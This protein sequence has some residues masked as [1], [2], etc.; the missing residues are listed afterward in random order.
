MLPE[1]VL[2]QEYLEDGQNKN[3]EAKKMVEKYDPKTVDGKF[4]KGMR[5]KFETNKGK[6]E[7]KVEAASMANIL[8]DIGQVPDKLHMMGS[9]DKPS[10]KP[11][12]SGE[13]QLQTGKGKDL[14]KSTMDKSY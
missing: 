12:K 7:P 8:K 10:A 13:N 2:L 9:P 11:Q 4:I 6:D 14:L 1:L 3:T 5:T